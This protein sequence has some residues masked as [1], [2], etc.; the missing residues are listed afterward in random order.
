MRWTSTSVGGSSGP[1]PNLAVPLME[2]VP[3]DPLEH[4]LEGLVTFG[5]FD[6]VRERCGA[7]LDI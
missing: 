5:A 7:G 3:C 2:N 4:V 6:A 1:R